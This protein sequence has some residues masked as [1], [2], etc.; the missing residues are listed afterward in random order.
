MHDVSKRVVLC[1]KGVT[2]VLG[3]GDLQWVRRCIDPFF[4]VGSTEN[5]WNYPQSA[6]HRSPCEWNA[7]LQNLLFSRRVFEN[8]ACIYW[9]EGFSVHFFFVWTSSPF[10]GNGPKPIRGLTDYLTNKI[11]SNWPFREFI[12]KMLVLYFKCQELSEPI[13]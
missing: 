9:K 2:G 4:I 13:S 3:N 5:R 10:I 1:K 8:Y 12:L 7:E 6:D 11:A